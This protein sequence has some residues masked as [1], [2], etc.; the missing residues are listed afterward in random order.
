MH[1]YKLF[2]KRGISRYLCYLG[3]LYEELA[4]S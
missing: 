3:I 4:V 2:N 1:E